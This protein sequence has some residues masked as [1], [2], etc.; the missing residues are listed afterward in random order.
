MIEPL[1]DL[2]FGERREQS[3]LSYLGNRIRLF[4]TVYDP[5]T[6]NYYIDISVFIG[7]FVGILSSLIL[8]WVLVRE[9]RK[10]IRAGR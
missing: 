4:C 10:S 1:K 5:A 2:V 3:S 7:T 8:G 6:D 9:W